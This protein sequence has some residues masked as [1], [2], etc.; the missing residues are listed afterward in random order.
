MTEQFVTS[1]YSESFLGIKHLSAPEV[2]NDDL[3]TFWITWRLTEGQLHPLAVTPKCKEQLLH[4]RI[5]D[6]KGP[7]TVM[8][9]YDR[10]AEDSP[11]KTYEWLER[12][13]EPAVDMI[14]RKRNHAEGELGLTEMGRPNQP[15][16]QH[17]AQPRRRHSS[18]VEAS[19]G[20]TSLKRE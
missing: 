20:S 12:E 13:M 18:E 9:E 3:E 17:V 10:A 5:N 19:S 6:A 15:K 2:V 8:A 7:S 14:R 16:K 11:T 1:D 4:R